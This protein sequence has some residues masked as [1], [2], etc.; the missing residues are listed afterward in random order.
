M[1]ESLGSAVLT[2]SVDDA[3][4]KAGLD[5]ARQAAASAGRAIGQALTGGSGIQ[6][7]NG[8]NI[9]L[10][11]LQ[12]E[13]QKV[14]IGTRRFRELREEIEKTERALNRAQGGG[15]A[16]PLGNIAT[17]VAG[18]GIGAG[19]V[20]FL[21][22]S[23]NAAVELESITKKLSNTLGPQGAGQ[24]LSFTKGLSDQLGL[25]FK[26]LANSFGSFTAAATAANVPLGEQRELFSAVARAAQALGLSNDEI[27]GSLLALQQVAAKGTVQMEELRGQLGERL[28]IAFG[29]TAKGLGITQQELIKLVESGKLTASQFFPALTKGLNELTEGAGGTATAAQ[30][31][32]KLA[33]AFDEL[34]TSFG[35]S[36]LPTVIEQVTR[37]TK[38]LE[39]AGVVLRANKLGLGG[40]AITN[41]L[42]VIPDQGAEAVGALRVLQDQFSLTE[43]QANALFTDAV[44]SVGGRTNAFGQLTLS[45]DQFKRVLEQLPSLAEQFRAKNKDVTGELNAQNAAAAR[46]LQEEL[47]RRDSLENIQ[48]KIK[49]LT[50][51]RVT[52]D[53]NSQRFQDV[54]VEI[55]A[56]K[57]RLEGLQRT[58]LRLDS[59]AGLQQQLSELE[60]RQ[61]KLSVDSS[62]FTAANQQ[63]LETQNA[64]EQ[65]DGKKAI[66]TVEQINAG[67]QDGSLTNNFSNLEKRSQAA[68]QALNS[69]AFGSPDFQKALRAAQEA[70]FEL[71]QRRKAADPVAFTKALDDSASRV[72]EA[73][74]KVEQASEALTS[75]QEGL[76]SSLEGAFDLLSDREQGA[77]LSA[78]KRDLQQAVDAR[79]FDGGKVAKLSD[80]ELIGAA[81]QARGILKANE[82]LNK[83]NNDLVEVN[84]DIVASNIDLIK[85]TQALTKKNWGVMVAV[86]ANTGD[87]AVNLG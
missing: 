68:Q 14:A 84:A 12:D 27:N 38:V 56:L 52:L 11:S 31:F 61:I 72:K 2:V 13:L 34:Q 69:A 86:N 16:G 85:A 10:N 73:F 74:G 9:K 44:A 41:A 21:R 17:A 58:P 46:L 19:A 55:D 75:A 53:V 26:T 78:A 50:A 7:L 22:G 60:A 65:L 67:V 5:R 59:I 24:A 3:Q 70:N 43:K 54:G 1:A 76:R 49:S 6:T 45:A 33:N 87:Y 79:I 32:Q 29:A 51:E 39:G 8:L 35:Q 57:G 15:G 23:I 71:D 64:L 36:L 62:A 48:E 80:K 47:K 83:A 25:S 30:N 81:S 37:L 4:F 66:I 18:L 63:I 28:P 20:G 77:I 82:N 40:G 42:G